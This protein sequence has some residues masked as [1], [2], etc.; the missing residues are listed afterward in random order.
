MYLV[1]YQI[2]VGVVRKVSTMHNC[3]SLSKSIILCRELTL[4]DR[5]GPATYE[6]KSVQVRPVDNIFVFSS[7]LCHCK[8]EPILCGHDINRHKKISFWRNHKV[9]NT[10][11]GAGGGGG[12]ALRG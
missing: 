12:A 8:A 11:F 7:A 5:N 6:L 10:K 9:I 1:Y 3:H 4:Q 2:H